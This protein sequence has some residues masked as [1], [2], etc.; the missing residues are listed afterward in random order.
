MKK[1]V[2]ST[3]LLCAVLICLAG[4]GPK[5]PAMAADGTPWNKDWTLVGL[6]LGVEEPGHGLTIRDN[7]DILAAV[8]MFYATWSIGE[9]ESY[10]NKDGDETDLYDAHLYLLLEGCGTADDAQLSVEDWMDMALERYTILDTR[11]ETYNGQDFTVIAYTLESETNP[12]ARGVSA[13]GAYGEWAIN[14][15]LTCR[16]GFQED[17]NTILA[18]FLSGCHYNAEQKGA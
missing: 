1:R 18:D 6:T 14:V 16:E 15:E 2:L 7:N 10:T 11:Q 4:C 13:F 3:I 17:L 5:E 12:Y 8:Q 9:A